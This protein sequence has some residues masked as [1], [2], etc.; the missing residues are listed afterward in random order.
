MKVKVRELSYL[1]S[2]N[3]SNPDGPSNFQEP[4][5]SGIGSHVDYARRRGIFDAGSLRRPHFPAHQPPS[6]SANHYSGSH[7][8]GGSS[9]MSNSEQNLTQV[10]WG[11]NINTNDVQVRFKNFLMNFTLESESHDI[12]ELSLYIKE[13]KAIAEME[14]TALNIDCAHLHQHDE[15]LYN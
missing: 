15:A 12:G 1:M 11:T 14:E 3:P 4:S 6:H 2:G 7:M 8:E 13:L 10:V 9:M 5:L